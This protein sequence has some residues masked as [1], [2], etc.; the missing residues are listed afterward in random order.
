MKIIKKDERLVDYDFEKSS[1]L[2]PRVPTASMLNL[3]KMTGE[4]F[5]TSLRLPSKRAGA[6]IFLSLRCMFMS[7]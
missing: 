3:P 4:R 7:N 2:S 6:N 1:P 5:R